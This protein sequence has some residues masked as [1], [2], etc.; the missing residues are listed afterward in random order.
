[1]AVTDNDRLTAITIDLIIPK[2][3]DQIKVKMPLLNLLFGNMEKKSGGKQLHVPVRYAFSDQVGSY[4]GLEVATFGLVDTRTRAVFEWKQ[5]RGRM[6]ISNIEQAKNAGE[7]KVVDLLAE[8]TKELQESMEDD[9]GDMFY[10]DGTGNSSKDFSGVSALIDDG[11]NIDTVGGIVRTSYTWWQSYYLASAGDQSLSMWATAYDALAPYGTVDFSFTTRAL[12]TGYE[13]LL[14]PQARYNF[15]QNGYPKADGGFPSIQFRGLDIVA[16]D[17]CQSGRIWL[18][19]KSHLG[20][21]WLPHPDY[22]TGK[23]GWATGPLEK[24]PGQDGKVR[25]VY[26]YGEAVTDKP[27]ALGQ[28]RGVT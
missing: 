22:P 26:L 6:A 13:A 20:I 4:A 5:Y 21:K 2:V 10:A 19:D 15:A 1:M 28:I 3:I 16:D 24:V 12:W 11:T 7:G 18:G 27:R 17:K 23:H 8:D 25:E 14:Q 9:L